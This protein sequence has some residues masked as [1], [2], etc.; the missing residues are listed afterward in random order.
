ML[1]DFLNT[2]ERK[3]ATWIKRFDDASVEER[4]ILLENLDLA[5]EPSNAITD[6]IEHRLKEI[7]R[8]EPSNRCAEFAIK[9]IN[10]KDFLVD[11]LEKDHLADFAAD[12]LAREP[13]DQ[14]SDLIRV[15][16]KILQRKILSTSRDDLPELVPYITTATTMCDLIV[17]ANPK[18]RES[19]LKN[20]IFKTEQGLSLLEKAA[21][22]KD[23]T[24]HK[25]ARNTLDEIRSL[26]KS[27]SDKEEE[28]NKITS[29]HKKAVSI[30][31]KT[32]QTFH[33]AQ[34][35]FN[36][37]EELR[38][39]GLFVR[40]EIQA[41]QSQ[42][43]K[44]LPKETYNELPINTLSESHLDAPKVDPFEEAVV[45]LKNLAAE[46]QKNPEDLRL[47]EQKARRLWSAALEK[48]EA[49]EKT[50]SE[51]KSL[52]KTIHSLLWLS[53]HQNELFDL[54]GSIPNVDQEKLKS[55]PIDE[56]QIFTQSSQEWLKLTQKFLKSSRED[57]VKVDNLV[58]IKELLRSSEQLESHLKKALSRITSEREN[59]NQIIR[60]SRE[61]IDKGR[62]IEAAKM[63][64]RAKK[65]K[66]IS[67]AAARKKLGEI[68]R[69]I[70]RLNNW[71]S[72]ADAPKKELLLQQMKDLS[73][74]PLDPESQLERIKSLR[75]SW[76]N[77]LKG[78]H[79][80]DSS[81]K[82][83]DAAAESAFSIC[84]SHFAELDLLK[85]RNTEKQRRILEQITAFLDQQNLRS[86]PTKPLEEVLRRARSEW[87]ETFPSQS[88]CLKER[89][90]QFEK[91]Q[92]NLHELIKEKK[93]ENQSKKEI[94]IE[95]AHSLC[96]EEPTPK[97]IEEIKDI[98]GEWRKTDRTHKKIEQI[99]WKRFRDI[100]DQIFHQ[101]RLARSDERALL[102]EKNKELE[103]KLTQVSNLIREDN[104]QNARKLFKEIE[105][106]MDSNPYGGGLL[107]KIEEVRSA[108]DE[109]E[110]RSKLERKRQAFE[111]L[112]AWDL[113]ISR[114]EE[115]G[116]EPPQPPGSFFTQRLSGSGSVESTLTLTL[117]AE[118]IAAVASPE[119]DKEERIKTQLALINRGI[120]PSRDISNDE[121]L[122]RWCDI[123]PKSKMDD[124]LRE[125]FFKALAARADS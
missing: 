29:T 87:N 41:L 15:H 42:L 91:S 113:K 125:R 10:D 54:L 39:R 114:F 107:K 67:G 35:E 120:K 109:L 69:D 63:A 74:N 121:L 20:E 32:R 103:A 16:P 56:V 94:L 124:P 28:W 13:L 118:I 93:N 4:V 38:R 110:A 47:N 64:A 55:M 1:K 30:F 117:E 71:K 96:Q 112:K 26:R 59:L 61:L 123:G 52:Q 105:I 3:T 53:I 17:K 37:I 72:F 50:S 18:L 11:L 97:V 62:S 86:T 7:V 98:Q 101:R 46:N 22:Q 6:K 119:I 79:H 21:R 58:Q 82:D 24:C 49:E 33:R 90:E 100:C 9:N 27:L 81:Q 23:K 80:K 57:D 78:S 88:D 73:R 14:I 43:L 111:D 31:A 76:N 116:G 25:F 85:V 51:F 45:L 95:R 34:L 108:L 102:Q 70:K 2:S 12:N 83:F 5:N 60:T 89:K 8:T 99:L 106:E 92:R 65:Y 66:S 104:L 19:L 44:R 36:R 122:E 77:L 84:E 68:N 40:D 48:Y 115:E 75:A